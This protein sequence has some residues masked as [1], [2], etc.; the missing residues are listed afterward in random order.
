MTVVLLIVGLLATAGGFVAIGFGIPNYAF[1]LGNTLIIAGSVS[2]ATGLILIGLAAVYGQLRRINAALK[3]APGRLGRAAE[4]I[5]AL[6]PPSARMT[7]VAPPSP[8]PTRAMPP[9]PDADAP[10]PLPPMFGSDAPQA[11]ELPRMP[12]PPPRM[13]E[14]PRMPEPPPR[15]PEPRMSEARMPELS[16]APEPRFPATA[17]E[18]APGPLDWLRSK[19]KPAA[20]SM[21]APPI[22]MPAASAPPMPAPAEPPVLEVPDEAPLSPR[23]PQRPMDR[24]MAAPAEPAPRAEPPMAQVE[25]ARDKDGFDLVWPDR[26]AASSATPASEAAKREPGFGMPLPPIPARP[27]DAKP[28]DR[29]PP[30]PANKV[31]AADRGPAIL[32]SGVID[33]MPYTLYADGSIEAELPQGTVKFASVDALRSHLEKQN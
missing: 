31:S 15:M 33:G 30:G 5:E 14:P 4:S 8:V 29:R 24:P 25:Q 19:S 18:P 22:P 32:K 27:R 1:G 2:S 10:P 21:P 28:A 13:A 3:G 17:S 26:G 23:P 12:E 16:R 9:R 11:A 20:P 6:V 7:P